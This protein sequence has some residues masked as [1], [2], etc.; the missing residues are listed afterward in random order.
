MISDR[1]RTVDA[2]VA[3]IFL[4]ESTRA[5]SVKCVGGVIVWPCKTTIE[6]HAFFFMARLT[7]QKQRR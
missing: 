1:C 2:L 7:E 6:Q 4:I 5:I 3:I